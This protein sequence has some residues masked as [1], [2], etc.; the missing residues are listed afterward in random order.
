[1]AMV[2]STAIYIG[3][4]AI[5]LHPASTDCQRT[6]TTVSGHLHPNYGPFMDWS[7]MEGMGNTHL[8]HLVAD[9][10]LKVSD[11]H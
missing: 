7:W 9:N 1:M 3:I 11:H 4:H 6:A 2:Y 8:Q 5:V 10:P